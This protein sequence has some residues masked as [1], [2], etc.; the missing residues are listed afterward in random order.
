M[1][2]AGERLQ[3]FDIEVF[4]QNPMALAEPKHETCYHYVG[5]MGSGVTELLVCSRPIRG[6]Y[7]RITMP[8]VGLPMHMCEVEVL[9]E[10]TGKFAIKWPV[11][12]RSKD[13]SS[14]PTRKCVR[15]FPSHNVLLSD[16]LSVCPTPRVY[17]HVKDPVVH[18]RVRWITE[19]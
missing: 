18:V 2:I 5:P 13:L 9:A 10:T 17:T 12:S 8:S 14:N 7:V 11:D 6:R 1:C 16:S 3:N 15:V 4:T 19:T